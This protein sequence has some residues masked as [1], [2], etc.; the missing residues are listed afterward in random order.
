M[1]PSRTQAAPNTPPKKVRRITDVLL[2]Y[3]EEL[4]QARPFPLVSEVD[5]EQ[6]SDVWNNCFLVQLQHIKNKENYSFTYFGEALQR[7]FAT[8][9][10]DVPVK[11]LVS[12][13]AER[14]ASQY[15]KVMQTGEPIIDDN[16]YENR[17]HIKVMYRQILLPLA[18]EDAPE[19]VAFILGGMRYKMKP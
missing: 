16:I 15:E 6:I 17:D 19:N 7:A 8:D 10:T 12:P 9:L 1:T 4:K 5:A 2:H 13:H 3:W 14:L 11:Y 18:S